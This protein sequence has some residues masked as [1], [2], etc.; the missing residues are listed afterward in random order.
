MV[1][2][3]HLVR[4]GEVFNPDRI[5]YGRMDGFRLSTRGQEMARLTAK[6]LSGLGRDVASVTASPLLRAQQTAAPIAEAL[7]ITRVFTDAG[8]IE[9]GNDFEGTSVGAQPWKLAAPRY[10][11][12]YR[13]VFTPSWGEPYADMVA[14]MSA[15]VERVRS[16]S[17]GRDAV[18][19]SHQLPIWVTRLYFEG[20]HLWHNPAR[21]QCTTCSITSLVFDDEGAFQK[22]EYAEPAADLSQDF[23]ADGW[24]AK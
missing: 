2:T 16:E 4:H 6:F 11:P 9:A 7:S 10:W 12:R 18:L 22:V 13:N 21:R 23:S 24:S 14:R 1:T 19:V 3:I 8:L 20:K 5:L 17:V 15:V